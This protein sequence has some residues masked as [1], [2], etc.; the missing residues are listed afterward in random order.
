M[1]RKRRKL[2]SNNQCF[3]LL[4]LKMLKPP[5][6]FP[7]FAAQ[8][9]RKPSLQNPPQFIIQLNNSPKSPWRSMTV[10]M[11][12]SFPPTQLFS[13]QLQEEKLFGC[14]APGN[15]IRIMKAIAF[16][17]RIRS[18]LRRVL[19]S[20]CVCVCVSIGGCSRKSSRV[21]H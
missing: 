16:R 19:A 20:G 18:C 5:A 17:S 3:F 15:R 2:L 13:T 8:L 11:N 21:G 14:Q 1:I 10:E 7:H 9:V 6:Q 4:T 12:F